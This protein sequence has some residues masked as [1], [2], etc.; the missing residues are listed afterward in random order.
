[1]LHGIGLSEGEVSSKQDWLLEQDRRAL[2][3]E[4]TLMDVERH[5][6]QRLIVIAAATAVGTSIGIVIGNWLWP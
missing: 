6:L 2:V 3:R 4:K 1:M 5:R